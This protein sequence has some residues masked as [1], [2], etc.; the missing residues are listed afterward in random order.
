[1]RNLDTRNLPRDTESADPGEITDT[2]AEAVDPGDPN[3]PELSEEQ[4]TTQMGS[5]MASGVQSM[6]TIGNKFGLAW[7]GMG[8]SIAS[9]G[10]AVNEFGQMWSSIDEKIPSF[11]GSSRRAS[12][13]VSSIDKCRIVPCF[14]P[15]PMF[16]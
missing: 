3:A 16:S 13:E 10:T 2:S 1:M 11:M 7:A 9:G 12:W 15:F 8:N 6:G 14:E 4:K 5:A